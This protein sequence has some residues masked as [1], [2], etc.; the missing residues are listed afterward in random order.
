MYEFL[1]VEGKQKF[2]FTCVFQIVETLDIL[3]FQTNQAE[4]SCIFLFQVDVESVS[5]STPHCCIAA[6][7]L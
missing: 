6:I 3:C 4:V 2:K 1:Y 7:S 5:V